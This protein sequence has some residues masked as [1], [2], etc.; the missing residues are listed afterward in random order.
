MA[1][2]HGA[3]GII[4]LS[5]PS[6]EKERPFA[7]GRE[8]RNM[9]GMGWADAGG[10]SPRAWPT[11]QN[12]ATV[13]VATARKLFAQS[14]TN[15][16]D[17]YAAAAANKPVR[18]MDLN[19]SVH[20]AK[21]SVRSDVASS[22]VVGMIEGSDPKLKNEY[23]V[24]SAHLD[25]LG[26]VKEKTGDN[27][28]N[29]AMDNASGV[30]TLLETARMFSQ[31]GARPKR[32]ILFLALTAEER[33]LLGSDYFA[34]NPTVPL[35]AI[36]A[37]VNLRLQGRDGV[38]GRAFEPEG[39]GAERAQENGPGPDPRPLAGKELLHP[40]RPLQLRAAGD[41]LAVPGHRHG[42]VQQG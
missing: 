33:G 42:L 15:L 14:G 26:V 32:S 39:H 37:N 10:K 3:V 29:G 28:Y 41:P 34:N 21:Q 30:A 9:P 23:V 40:L 7:R 27:I 17:I 24:Y 13:S 25:H 5:T 8:F 22:N 12:Q 19:L 18:G 4:T 2:K 31:S 11:L 36:V 1:F 20:M 38:R 6:S 16:D 35:E